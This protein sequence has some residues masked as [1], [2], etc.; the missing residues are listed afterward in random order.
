[1]SRFLLTGAGGMLGGDLRRAL[2]GRQVSALGRSQLDVTDLAAVRRAVDGHDVVINAAAF[3]R[4]DD[5]ESHEAEAH[6]VNAVGAENLA[7]AAREHGARLIQV[8]TDYVFSGS[9]VGPFEENHPLDPIS[10]YGR[11]K[12]DGERMASR[13]HPDGTYIV[14]TAWL[15]GAGGPNFARTI[16]RLAREQSTINVVDD[17]RGQPTWSADLARQIVALLD[18]DAHAGIYHATNSGETTWFNFAR[19]ILR[20]AGLDPERILPTTSSELIRPAARPAHSAL[21]DR[22]MTAAGLEPMRDWHEALRA[23]W[24]SGALRA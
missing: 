9:G 17:Q 19:E 20:V 16:L 24:D 13:A 2:D 23:A 21:R 1:M 7:I 22:A 10:A 12:A 3:T 5:A 15:Y 18:S 14:R 8:S 4:V 11:T 6:A